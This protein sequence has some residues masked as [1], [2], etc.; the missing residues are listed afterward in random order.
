MVIQAYADNMKDMAVSTPAGVST[1]MILTAIFVYDFYGHAITLKIRNLF[2]K[3][4]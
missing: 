2:R 3:H 1:I 4:V